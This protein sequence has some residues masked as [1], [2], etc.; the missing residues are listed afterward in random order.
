MSGLRIER[1]YERRRASDDVTYVKMCLSSLVTDTLRLFLRLESFKKSYR[2][3]TLG[4]CI[5]PPPLPGRPR[6]NVFFCKFG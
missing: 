5:N 1:A 2:G 3:E 4:S 6:V